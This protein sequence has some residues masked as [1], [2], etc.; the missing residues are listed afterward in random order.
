MAD[1]P[2]GFARMTIT[3][4]CPPFRLF[5]QISDTADPLFGTWVFD[6]RVDREFLLAYYYTCLNYKIIDDHNKESAIFKTAC[7]CDGAAGFDYTV[8]TLDMEL[9][10][11]QEISIDEITQGRIAN[12][13]D[14]ILAIVGGSGTLT[15][16]AGT[17]RYL[18]TA[19]EVN[20]MCINSPT[21]AI[22]CLET[23]QLTIQVHDPV[24]SGSYYVVTNIKTCTHI[25]G[26]TCGIMPDG[27]DYYKY[28]CHND[29]LLSVVDPTGQ[30]CGYCSWDPAV[31]AAFH[32]YCTEQTTLMQQQSVCW[33][34]QF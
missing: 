28:D 12:C 18:Y 3:E 13:P 26:G 17:N 5:H 10:E 16:I 20:P 33:Y 6:G 30:G 25:L 11:T 32:E 7:C 2:V 1:V 34:N 24:C 29:L 4:G 15:P 22:P 23:Q 27:F 21:F 9:R 31:V 14:T 8:T 19:P